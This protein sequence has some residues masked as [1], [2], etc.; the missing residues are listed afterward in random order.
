MIRTII[1]ELRSGE[2]RWEI[3][4]WELS[5]HKNCDLESAPLVRGAASCDF[6]ATKLCA[7]D[8]FRAQTTT[9]AVGPPFEDGKD[10]VSIAVRRPSRHGRAV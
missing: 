3:R 10:R 8:V 4:L 1:R 5:Y 9:A 7:H 2:S 6:I